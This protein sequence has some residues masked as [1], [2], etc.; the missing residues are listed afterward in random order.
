MPRHPPCREST[1]VPF[2]RDRRDR[3]VREEERSRRRSEVPSF[4]R[5]S[6]FRAWM[7]CRSDLAERISRRAL[8]PVAPDARLATRTCDPAEMTSPR[9][10]DL[11]S[12]VAESAGPTP[13]DACPGCHPPPSPR[14]HRT[15]HRPRERR[16]T[17]CFSG[18]RR[19]YRSLQLLRCTGTLTSCRPSSARGRRLCPRPS[20]RSSLA[21]S[22]RRG[23]SPV[24]LRVVTKI[25]EPC[26]LSVPSARPS[27]GAS[28]PFGAGG[29]GL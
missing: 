6:S 11:P 2:S 27:Q 8:R 10:L 7:R 26:R 16:R 1:R 22:S 13:C 19:H 4:D 14:P 9:W 28:A 5:R 17:R 15:G 24:P 3:S 20:P 23:P 29:A 12:R 18:P 25:E 21:R